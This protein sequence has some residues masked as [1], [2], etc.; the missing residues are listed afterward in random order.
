VF[1]IACGHPDGND[2]DALA[3][4]PIHK[5]VIDRD[6][7]DGVRLASQPTISRSEQ[8]AAPRPLYRMAEALADRVVARHQRRRRQA[9]LITLDVDV[10]ADEAYRHWARGVR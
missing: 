5:L 7:I 4:D 8:A 9:R 6:P 1:A 3:H 2:G 10:T